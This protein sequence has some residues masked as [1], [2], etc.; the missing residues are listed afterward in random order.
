MEKIRIR[1]KHFGSATLDDMLAIVFTFMQTMGTDLDLIFCC[2]TVKQNSSKP[3]YRYVCVEFFFYLFKKGIYLLSEIAVIKDH[4][5]NPDLDPD[6]D[7]PRL[8]EACMRIQ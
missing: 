8:Q 7:S 4:A 1:D 5:L 3:C 6:Q 2:G